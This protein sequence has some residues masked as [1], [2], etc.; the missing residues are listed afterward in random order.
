[1]LAA[2]ANKILCMVDLNERQEKAARRQ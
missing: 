2:S 1:M